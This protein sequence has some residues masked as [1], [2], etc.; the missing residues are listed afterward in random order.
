MNILE[1]IAAKAQRGDTGMSL[2][3]GFLYSCIVGMETKNVFE[4]GSGFSTHVILHALEKT[5][6]TL[7]SCDVTNYS[8][9]PNIT[10]FTKASKRWNFYHGN[11]TEIFNDIGY[12]F[13]ITFLNK[14]DDI[15]KNTIA[16]YYQRCFGE[17]LPESLANIQL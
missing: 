9:N 8:D 14:C 7:T 4:F 10:D 5:G 17:D 15:E 2:H 3:Y 13:R 11:S 16:E 1:Q 12:A 6:G